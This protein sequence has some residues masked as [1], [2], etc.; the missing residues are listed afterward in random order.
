MERKGAVLEREFV[1][2][3]LTNPITHSLIHSINPQNSTQ[4]NHN[5]IPQFFFINTHTPPSFIS[6]IQINNNT[7]LNPQSNPSHINH[8]SSSSLKSISP[9]LPLSVF[10]EI[11]RIKFPSSKSI[12]H[13]TPSSISLIV[14]EL[15]G[16][17]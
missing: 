3:V 15:C 5:P 1:F 14:N 9:S 4:F 2:V 8:P 10:D 12:T 13:H 6:I 7:C 11:E 16:K 17:R